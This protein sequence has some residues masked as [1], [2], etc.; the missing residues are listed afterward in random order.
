[1]PSINPFFEY[2]ATFRKEHQELK[3]QRVIAKRAKDAWNSL[4]TQEKNIYREQARDEQNRRRRVAVMPAMPC[5]RCRYTKLAFS[6]LISFVSEYSAPLSDI[7]GTMRF[8]ELQ[9]NFNRLMSCTFRPPS[10]SGH[11]VTCS[12]QLYDPFSI[13]ISGS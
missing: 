4:T 13:P 1:M 7:P 8:Q 6:A 12:S 2:V 5:Q 11:L 9:P 10:K 3:E